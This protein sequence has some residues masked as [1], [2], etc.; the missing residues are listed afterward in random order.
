MGPRSNA[1]FDWETYYEEYLDALK[2]L[3][4]VLRRVRFLLGLSPSG[5][6]F[7]KE[8][9]EWAQTGEALITYGRHYANRVLA[10]PESVRA[11]CVERVAPASFAGLDDSYKAWFDRWL[12]YCHR[13]CTDSDSSPDGSDR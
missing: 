6:P 9:R 10:F 8:T 2:E 13:S 7:L 1:R 3:D 11:I 5:V 4:R 12:A